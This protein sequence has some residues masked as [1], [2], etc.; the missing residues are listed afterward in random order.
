MKLDNNCLNT[1]TLFLNLC[2]YNCIHSFF[3]CIVLA[4][5]YI[6][7]HFIT[8]NRYSLVGIVVN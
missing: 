4:A 2:K 1:L 8:S 3:F 5:I 6:H 7:K